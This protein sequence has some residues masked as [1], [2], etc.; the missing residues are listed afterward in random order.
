MNTAL[1]DE[2]TLPTVGSGN[3]L[4][5]PADIE[6]DGIRPTVNVSTSDAATS[7]AVANAGTKTITLTTSEAVEVA[8]SSVLTELMDDF[9]VTNT[10]TGNTNAVT[11]VAVSGTTITLTVTDTILNAANLTVSYARDENNLITDVN[12][13]NDMVSITNARDITVVDD[14]SA[15]EIT[16]VTT[17]ASAGTVYAI[18]DVIPIHVV[19]N[20]G[21]NVTDTPTLK[22][23]T[24]DTDA[25]V[26]YASRTTTT[27]EN[28]TLVF[29]YTVGPGQA[30][31]DLGTHATAPLGTAGTIVDNL[32]TVANRSLPA[33]ASGDALKDP[34][35][36]VVDGIRPTVNASTNDAATSGAVAN[37]GTKVI[38][39]TTSEAVEV[40][41]SSVL[42]E[43]VDDFTILL[44]GQ[45]KTIESISVSGTSIQLNLLEYIP[46]SAVLTVAYTRDDGNVVSD[47][48]AGNELVSIPVPREV[49]IVNDETAPSVVSVSGPS[50][51]YSDGEVVPISILFDEVV[52]VT[53]TP[54]LEFE[55]GAKADY[56]SGSGSADKTLI[57]NYTIG[58]D[59]S[60][61]TSDLQYKDVNSFLFVTQDAIVKD[62]ANNL[63]DLELPLTNSSDSLAGSSQ[64]E[65]A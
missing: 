16:A 14:V 39:L 19:F 50:D 27:V 24:G 21:V 52:L 6:I 44:D 29:N 56:Q 15:P 18:G 53:G 37:A 64:I 62:P 58:S 1:A 17:S 61:H 22:L 41:S 8:S 65:I 13:G 11:A 26:N 47:V 34:A 38:T 30:T 25:I 5:D 28:D 55:S 45:Q 36:I 46:N 42:T 60:E 10:S 54:Q 3:A 51:T 2:R 43:L 31:S 7:G 23:E 12:A 57:F 32:N 9:T 63:A 35:D 48:N 59:V 33:V 49:K 20:E 40:A 4:K